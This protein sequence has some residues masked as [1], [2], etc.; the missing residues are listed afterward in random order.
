MRTIA[1][2]VVCVRSVLVKIIALP[3]LL[4][5][6]DGDGFVKVSEKY[7]LCGHKPNTDEHHEGSGHEEENSLR[8][9]QCDV[10]A[11]HLSKSYHALYVVFW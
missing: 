3:L 4:F 10:P 8:F 11:F 9:V 1:V 2:A 5:I 6:H 7:F